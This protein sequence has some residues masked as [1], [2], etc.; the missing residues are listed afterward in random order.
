MGS[1]FLSYVKLILV[2][3]IMDKLKLRA[4]MYYFCRLE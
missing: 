3:F 4:Y 2:S 1:V